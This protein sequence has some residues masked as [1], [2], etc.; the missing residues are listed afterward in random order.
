[1]ALFTLL[2]SFIVLEVEY[3]F[4]YSV[5]IDTIEP[6]SFTVLNIYE[7]DSLVL[8]R[9]Y[10]SR[11]ERNTNRIISDKVFLYLK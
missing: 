9:S 3:V 5:Y 6:I 7:L 1:V 10:I 4:T 8:S 2:P 11:K